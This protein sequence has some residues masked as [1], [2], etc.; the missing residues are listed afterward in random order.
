MFAPAT[1]GS[2]WAAVRPIP[3]ASLWCRCCVDATDRARSR[4]TGGLGR[5]DPDQVAN[6]ARLPSPPQHDDD[7]V[8]GVLG[9]LVNT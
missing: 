2:A 6:V 1:P 4:S 7:S 5:G 8:A 9:H 3:R